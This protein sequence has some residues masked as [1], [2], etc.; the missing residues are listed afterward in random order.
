MRASN[1]ETANREPAPSVTRRELGR[2]ALA[3]LVGAPLVAACQPS[4]P[5]CNDVSTLPPADRELR[6]TL[7]YV[8]KSPDPARV[9]GGCVQY[10]AS[11]GAAPGETP[12][13]S[14]CGRCQI[15]RG[16]VSPRGQCKRWAASGR[17]G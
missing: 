4:A 1:N 5:T 10:G 7:G 17:T 2:I 16:P 8:D 12:L 9:C 3:V 13:P 15:L 6:V 11:E 14:G